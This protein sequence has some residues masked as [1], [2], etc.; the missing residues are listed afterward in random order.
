MDISF[1]LVLLSNRTKANVQFRLNLYTFISKPTG[2]KVAR[3]GSLVAY[4]KHCRENATGRYETTVIVSSS[5]ILQRA[6]NR[7]PE[8]LGEPSPVWPIGAIAYLISL[9][10]GISMTLSVLRNCLF[11]EGEADSLE[12]L[13]QL[14][15]R[16]IR[17][18]TEYELGYSR[19]ATLKQALNKEIDK[20]ARERGQKPVELVDELLEGKDQSV[21]SD[22]IANAVD[23]LVASKHEKQLTE[24]RD[25]LKS[26]GRQG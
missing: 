2:D 20:A 4:L 6:A 25:T 26:Q 17:Q 21:L 15:S 9:I 16:V 24:L 10:P 3:D 13:A 7:F 22:V 11:D 14:A 19:R 8:Q 18:S 12:R 1:R 23:Q 5:P